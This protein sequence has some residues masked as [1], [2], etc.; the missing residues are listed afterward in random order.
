ML[1]KIVLLCPDKINTNYKI[2]REMDV[3]DNEHT[4]FITDSKQDLTC[5][6]DH[7]CAVLFVSRDNGFVTGAKY[8]T[9]SLE[10]CDDEYFNTVFSRQK[11]IPLKIFETA[12]T[13]VRE[14]TVKDLE[15]LYIIYEDTLVKK[16]I[17][18]LHE[19]EEEKIYTEKYIENM[20]GLYGYG[21]WIV[22]DKKTDNIIGRIG[23]SIKNIDG[24]D[25]KE[26][27][28]VIR[29]EYR[30]RGYAYEVCADVLDYALKKPDIDEMYTVISMEN[31]A[32]LRLA[33]KLGFEYYDKKMQKNTYYGIF[34]KNLKST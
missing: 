8:I 6:N 32:S 33:G 29:K 30:R 27:G 17:E 16:Y 28:Y 4:L 12:R 2:V 9:E 3:S 11:K 13:V 18:P 21:L 34:K 22:V 14:M 31:E 26:L 23:I 10:D 7:N 20:Y 25:K 19:Y 15:E 1:N 24:E 5:L